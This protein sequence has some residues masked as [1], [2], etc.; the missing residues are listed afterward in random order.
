MVF[1][2]SQQVVVY[3]WDM[4]ELRAFIK[5]RPLIG[6]CLQ[7]AIS[8]DFVNKVD[9]SRGHKK[10][11]R[12]LLEQALEGGEINLTEKKKLQR[13]VCLWDKGR[14]QPRS[15]NLGNSLVF[16]VPPCVNVFFLRRCN[17]RGPS[18]LSCP[19]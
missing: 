14:C 11:Y 13:Y 9:Q 10:R 17:A 16:S 18:S 6:A 8:E 5:R 19:T 4:H 15:G 3:A 2:F 12:L 7:K 1:S